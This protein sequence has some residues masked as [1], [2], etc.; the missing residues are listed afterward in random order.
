[1]ARKIFMAICLLVAVTTAALIFYFFL[2]HPWYSKWGATR[3]EVSVRLPG[4][5]MVLEPKISYTRAIDINAPPF[6]VWPWL[7]QMGQGRGG[8]YSYDWLENLFGLDIHSADRII[9][10]Y[11]DL[12][13]GDRIK[14]GKNFPPAIPVKYIEARRAL[15]MGGIVD[16]ATGQGLEPGEL[17]PQKYFSSSWSFNLDSKDGKTTRLVVRGRTDYNK[18][19]FN[20]LACR[21][22]LEPAGFIMERK[23]LQGIKYRA[24]HEN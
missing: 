7:V 23:M 1:M 20:F 14:I 17:F 8:L 3:E 18:S 15:V 19:L 4:D 16:T 6:K 22:I 10:Q 24:E 2:V 5:E 11:Q 21:V 13:V 12:K 9:M